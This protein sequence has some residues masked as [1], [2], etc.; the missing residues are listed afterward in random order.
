MVKFECPFC[1]EEKDSILKVGVEVFDDHMF[2]CSDALRSCNYT[3]ICNSCFELVFG[4]DDNDTETLIRG[5]YEAA[6][7]GKRN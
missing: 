2:L 6:T 3:L 4:N 1:K 5:L 7:D